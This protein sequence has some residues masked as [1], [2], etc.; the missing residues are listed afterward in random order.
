M[1]SVSVAFLS[2]KPSVS[3]NSVGHQTGASL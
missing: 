2:E 1:N 3:W